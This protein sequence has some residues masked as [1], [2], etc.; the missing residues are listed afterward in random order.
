MP[1]DVIFKIAENNLPYLKQSNLDIVIDGKTYIT[2][3]P[4]GEVKVSLEAGS[5]SIKMSF[6]YNWQDIS[7]DK[8]PDEYMNPVELL[9]SICLV[10][11]FC[12]GTSEEL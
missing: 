5:H 12:S 7:P 6:K 1:N 11:F 10:T 2:V 8:T 9:T 4:A 3:P